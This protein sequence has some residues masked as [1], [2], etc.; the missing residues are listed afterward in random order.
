MKNCT[1]FK[2]IFGGCQLGKPQQHRKQA[3]FYSLMVPSFHKL[4][5]SFI[6]KTESTNTCTQKERIW[7]NIILR[8]KKRVL[9]SPELQFFFFF[10][11]LN[12]FFLLLCSLNFPHADEK[13]GR[14]A[15][16]NV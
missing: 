15:A 7:Q 5:F 11:N 10:F 12:F 4:I 13:K 14:K 1:I 2:N 16:K 6:Y 3:P 9:F 8:K